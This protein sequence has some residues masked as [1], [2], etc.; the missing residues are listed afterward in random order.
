MT[1]PKLSVANV[2]SL[3]THLYETDAECEADFEHAIND[4]LNTGGEDEAYGES[5]GES[6]AE[7]DSSSDDPD[8]PGGEPSPA[9]IPAA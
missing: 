1:Q 9:E 6:K 8:A 3:A 2:R 7:L 5:A 4:W